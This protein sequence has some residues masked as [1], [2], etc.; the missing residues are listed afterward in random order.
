MAIALPLPR[1]SADRVQFQ[2][3]MAEERGQAAKLNAVLTESGVAMAVTDMRPHHFRREEVAHT[4]LDSVA[5]KRIVIVR[6]PETMAAGEHFIVDTPTAGRA[7]FK[8]HQRET[9]AQGIQQ[10]IELTRLRIGGGKSLMAWLHQLAVH[11]P[12]HIVDMMLAKQ[13]AHTLQQVIKSFRDIQV[14]HQL[15]AAGSLPVT[16]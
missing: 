8:L 9:G 16:R 12:L 15:M 14:Q 11:I 7:G 6:C 3:H 13:P 4:A 1:V 10:A 2:P 5:L